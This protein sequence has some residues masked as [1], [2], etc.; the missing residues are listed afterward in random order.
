MVYI[1]NPQIDCLPTTIKDVPEGG[2]VGISY[3]HTQQTMQR[4]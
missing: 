1:L 3:S 2:A 4:R